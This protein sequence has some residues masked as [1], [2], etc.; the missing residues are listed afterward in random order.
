[1]LGDRPSRVGIEDWHLAA[2]YSAAISKVSPESKLVGISET[3]MEMRKTKGR[4]ELESLRKANKILDYAYGA[5]KENAVAGKTELDLFGEMNR[6]ALERFGPLAVIGGDV[7]SSTRTLAVGGLPTSRKLRRGDTVIIDMQVCHN[8]YWADTARTFFVGPP[9][10]KQRRSTRTK[11]WSPPRLKR[12]G[13]SN[14]GR[15]RRASQPLSTG[16]SLTAGTAG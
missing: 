4:D 15:Q 6:T 16:S 11:Q 5:A 14:R 13:C 3:I 2:I 7:V 1:M 9:S 10:E 12:L 8:N